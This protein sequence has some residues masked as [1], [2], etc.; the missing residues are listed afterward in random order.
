VLREI[1]PHILIVGGDPSFGQAAGVPVG[2]DCMAGAGV[3]G[4]PYTALVEAPTEQVLVMACDM[5][6]LTAPFLSHLAS[7]DA[8][9]DAAAPRAADGLHPL[10]ACDAR[11]VAGW[12]KARIDTGELRV[13]DGLGE[14]HV[15]RVWPDELGPFT[16]NRRLLLNVNT[17]EDC[18]RASILE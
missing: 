10:C 15:R 3:L 9:V 4:G 14:L 8:K 11:G 17:P 12:L 18:Q 2:A 7:L 5:P 1:T 13:I 16:R 6:F